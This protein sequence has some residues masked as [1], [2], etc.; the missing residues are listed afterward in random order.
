MEL[1]NIIE[2]V[3]KSIKNAYE[4]KSK[5]PEMILEMEGMSGRKT[6]HLYN[7]LCSAGYKNYLEVGTWKGSSFIS[8]M[9]KNNVTGY[10]VDNW[11]EF[12]GPKNEFYSNLKTF[13]SNEEY[14]THDKDSWLVTKQDVPCPIDIFL[15][16]G[17]HS[18]EAHKKAI[19]Y[20]HTFLSKY[21]II[22]IDDW[23]LVDFPYIKQV[24]MDGFRESNLTIHYTHEIP[25]VNTTQ[26]SQKGNTFWNGCGIFVVE[27]TDLN[28]F[29]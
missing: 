8:A 17:D 5:L 2:H 12:N 14:H 27:R 11:S 24:T 3:K 29:S 4:N 26:Y 15:Y 28:T 19:T 13:L 22:I 21:A 6:R 10:C 25:L 16:D 9:Y 1:Y 20:F 7:N 18:A 23:C